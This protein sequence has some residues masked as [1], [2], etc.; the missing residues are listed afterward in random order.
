MKCTVSHNAVLSAGQQRLL[1]C[2]PP[3][4]GSSP[5]IAER[6]GVAGRDGSGA[7]SRRAAVSR[8]CRGVECGVRSVGAD[9]KRTRLRHT[10]C[11]NA[12]SPRAFP[13]LLLLLPSPLVREP[14]SSLSAGLRIWNEHMRP[15]RRPHGH[16]GAPR[17]CQTR[18][19]VVGRREERGPAAVSRKTRSRPPPPGALG[20]SGPCRAASGRAA[21]TS[22]PNVRTR[23]CRSRP[24]P[25]CPCPGPDHTAGRTEA[26]CRA[27]RWAARCA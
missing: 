17:D 24:S 15:S 27:R 6:G 8:G 23:L 5:P 25:R 26:L 21:T 7:R 20:K 14:G 11:P 4:S 19:D 16:H 22:G 18:R 10:S 1:Q 2:S 13:H 3:I 12:L 9:I